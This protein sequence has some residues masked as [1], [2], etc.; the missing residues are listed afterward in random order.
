M[1][2]GLKHLD[3]EKAANELLGEVQERRLQ[4]EDEMWQELD[5]HIFTWEPGKRRSGV[6]ERP[7]LATG[8]KQEYKSGEPGARP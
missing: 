7:N 2:R 3:E 4:L 8:T 6:S 1:M 5:N